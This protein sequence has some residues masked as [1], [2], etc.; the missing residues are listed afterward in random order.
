MEVI[1]YGSVNTMVDEMKISPVM[2]LDCWKLHLSR[3][4]SEDAGDQSILSHFYGVVQWKP[5]ALQE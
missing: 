4:G 2:I 1:F 3:A 5:F